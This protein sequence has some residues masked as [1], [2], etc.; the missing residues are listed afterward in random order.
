[1]RSLQRHEALEWE[2]VADHYDVHLKGLVR[3]D[4]RW[5][6][7]E[8]VSDPWEFDQPLIYLVTP[9][10]WRGWMR[11]KVRQW[12]F[13]LCVGTHWSGSKRPRKR[14]RLRRPRWFWKRV[15]QLYYWVKRCGID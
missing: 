9:L 4:G 1:M 12:G 10:S 8:L 2:F 13:E 14:Y 5:C 6:E 7:A 15:F 11:W 3:C